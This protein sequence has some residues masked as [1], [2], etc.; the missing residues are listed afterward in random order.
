[1]P[2]VQVQ[3]PFMHLMLHMARLSPDCSD[4]MIR[5]TITAFA[6]RHGQRIDHKTIEAFITGRQHG[7]AGQ[8]IGTPRDNSGDRLGAYALG[9]TAPFPE[10]KVPVIDTLPGVRK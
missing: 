7:R 5:A 2:E 6:N 4:E 10:P 8:T 9:Y 1:M 3:D